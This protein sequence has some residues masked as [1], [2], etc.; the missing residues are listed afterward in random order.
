M[1]ESETCGNIQK[2]FKRFSKKNLKKNYFNK[3]VINNWNELPGL[4]ID[5]KNVKEIEIKKISAT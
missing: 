4:F 2:T 5:S 1:N 3:R